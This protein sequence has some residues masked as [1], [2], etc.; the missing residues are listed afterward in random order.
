MADKE[1]VSAI[2]LGKAARVVGYKKEG[3]HRIFGD[4]DPA[5][6]TPE[7]IEETA[8]ARVD[9]EP[10]K[11]KKGQIIYLE[12]LVSYMKRVEEDAEKVIRSEY[13]NI[14]VSETAA[15]AV[16]HDENPYATMAAA[17]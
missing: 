9:D 10:E 16:K 6:I 13:K 12:G 2:N 17:I 3:Y 8:Q 11:N 7:F 14:G 1:K 15:E 5:T 4:K